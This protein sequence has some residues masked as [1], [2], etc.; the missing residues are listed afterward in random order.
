MRLTNTASDV[1]I[2]LDF[3]KGTIC[4]LSYRGEE[5]L[6]KESELFSIRLTDRQG[7]TVVY[8]SAQ[9]RLIGVKGGERIE[10][11]YSDF[12]ESIAVT[13]FIAVKETGFAVRFAVQ[14]GTDKIVEHIEVCPIVVKPFV[15]NGGI[16]RMLFP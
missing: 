1:K 13:V 8:S 9:A 3:P 16:G 12:P 6:A 15:K 14:N 2:E 4:S 10:A 5:I 11:V 7:N